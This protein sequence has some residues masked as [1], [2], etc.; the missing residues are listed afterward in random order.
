MRMLLYFLQIFYYYREL[1]KKQ[2]AVAPETAKPTKAAEDAERRKRKLHNHRTRPS[3][4]TA[5]QDKVYCPVLMEL[6]DSLNFQKN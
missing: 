1:E 6:S 3:Y 2:S 4:F 5:H